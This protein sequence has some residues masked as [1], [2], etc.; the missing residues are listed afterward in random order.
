L[1]R[2]RLTASNTGGRERDIELRGQCAR[3]FLRLIV[4]ALAE[5][6]CVQRHGDQS[7][8][9][10]SA[11]VELGGE[12]EPE[13]ATEHARAVELERMQLTVERACIN[14]RSD[15][16]VDVPRVSRLRAAAD[17]KR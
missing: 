12:Q 3:D 8:G 2:R 10:E 6:L 5:P 17:R 4:A 13:R 16:R 14:V 9:A 15:E 11:A 1:R 7:I